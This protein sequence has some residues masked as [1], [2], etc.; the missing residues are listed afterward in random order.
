MAAVRG[1][2]SDARRPGAPS[3]RWCKAERDAVV[4]PGSLAVI[5]SRAQVGAVT[6]AVAGG[7]GR[8]ALAEYGATDGPVSVV[9]VEEV[10]GLEFDGVVLVEP[11]AILA[12]SPRG[13]SDLYVAMTRPTQR[14]VVAHASCAAGRARRPGPVAP[15][16]GR[17][18]KPT[19][20][21]RRRNVGRKPSCGQVREDSRLV[22]RQSTTTLR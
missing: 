16:R 13:A 2:A 15:G 3:S 10:K 5:T 9:T 18:Q 1:P 20:R 21:C 19:T 6:A 4:A 8:D 14:L 22:A 17:P 11:S 12:E 7:L